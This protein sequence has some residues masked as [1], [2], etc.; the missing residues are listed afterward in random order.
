[1]RP[2]PEKEKGRKDR[3]WEEEEEEGWVWW[4]MPLKPEFGRQADQI[5]VG[6]KPPWFT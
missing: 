3:G 4:Y 1:M 2:Y 6:S 5:S